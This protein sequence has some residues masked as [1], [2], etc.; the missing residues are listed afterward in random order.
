MAAAMDAVRILDDPRGAVVEYVATFLDEGEHE[1][2]LAELVAVRER[3]DRD[4]V[5]LYGKT[6]DSPRLV[7]AFGDDG[8]HY[9]YA[10][11]DR[12]TH[13]W[14]PRLR[15]ARDRIA[16]HVGHPFNYALVNLYRDGADY[17]GWHA[18]KVGD[19]VPGST[20]ASLSL[21]AA[22]PFLLRDKQSGDTREVVLAGGSL[23]TMQGTCQQHYK[24]ALPRRRGVAGARYNVTLRRI[25][26]GA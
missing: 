22:R 6:I 2:L 4:R 12:S 24:H 23:L 9:R 3:F 14:P 5:V 1:A 11:V 19:L 7:C 15:A 20:I 17:I 8:L 18:D 26:A 13:T 16:A 10:G 21:G 25:K